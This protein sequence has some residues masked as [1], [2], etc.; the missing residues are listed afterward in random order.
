MTVVADLLARC[1][2]AGAPLRLDVTG[3]VVADRPPPAELAAAVRQHREAIALEL[4]RRSDPDAPGWTEA[5]G[6]LAA[7]AREGELLVRVR[8]GLGFEVD[9]A[10]WRVLDRVL[11]ARD[12][13]LADR[14]W[15]H[16]LDADRRGIYSRLIGWLRSLDHAGADLRRV[17]GLVETGPGLHPHHDETYDTPRHRHHLPGA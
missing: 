11:G 15:R 16:V 5:T 13:A 7:C 14:L 9:G 17:R 10:L 12:L 6:E 1:A 3:H 4:R 2:A 8:T